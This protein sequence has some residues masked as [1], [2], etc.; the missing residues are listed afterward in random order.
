MLQRVEVNEKDLRLLVAALRNEADG[1]ELGRDL[2]RELT[3][4]AEPAL[5]AAQAELMSMGSTSEALPGLRSTVVRH[6]KIRVRL[7]GRR[8]GVA[9]VSDKN[10]M[11]RGFYNAPKRLNEARGWRH[12]VFGNAERW[13]WQRGKPGWFDDTISKFKPAAQRAAQKALDDVA[14]RIDRRT[15]G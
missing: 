8:P 9:I 3:K 14:R 15:K 2:V 4:A 13:V 10:G 1:K 6:T 7:G 5:R 11:P 12:M